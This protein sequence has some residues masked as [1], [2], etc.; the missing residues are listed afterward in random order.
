MLSLEEILESTGRNADPQPYVAAAEQFVSDG[1]LAAAASAYDRT[2]GLKENDSQLAAARDRVLEQFTVVEHGITFRYVPA[3]SYLMGSASGDDDEAPVHAVRLDDFWISDAPISWA[4]YCELM[5]WEPP[6]IG[7]PPQSL[8]T[9]QDQKETKFDESLF[10]LQQLCK[11][12]LQYCEDHTT[13]AID[14]HAHAPSQEWVDG[15]GKAM[16][17]KALFGTPPRAP[18]RRADRL[19]NEADGCCIVAGRRGVL[20]GDH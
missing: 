15:K 9:G 11:M 12:R 5:K 13:R 7:Q 2:Y 10:M 14:W 18:S 3:G 20:P 1:A 17:S 16:S 6:P 4:K 8:E 19:H